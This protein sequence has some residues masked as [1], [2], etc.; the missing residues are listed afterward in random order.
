MKVKVLKTKEPRVFQ[1]VTLEITLDTTD[2]VLEMYHRCLVPRSALESGS[3]SVGYNTPFP[4]GRGKTFSSML[5][6]ALDMII[7]AEGLR[8][9]D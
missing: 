6:E 8:D 5:F 3:V 4:E 9:N 1:P 2:E 7:R